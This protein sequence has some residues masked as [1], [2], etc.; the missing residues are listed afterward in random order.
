MNGMTLKPICMAA[1]LTLGLPVLSCNRQPSPRE[2]AERLASTLDR[3]ENLQGNALWQTF[4]HR[5]EEAIKIARGGAIPSEP[6]LVAAVLVR[7]EKTPRRG[8]MGLVW[9]KRED[10][11]DY[12]TVKCVVLEAEGQTGKQAVEVPLEGGLSLLPRGY[13]WEQL[14]DVEVVAGNRIAYRIEK[15]TDP[16]TEAETMTILTI[17]EERL[18]EELRVFLRD[19]AGRTSDSLVVAKLR[20]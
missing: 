8:F 16:R 10:K 9:L 4:P 2:H 1:A 17:G 14:I 12:S 6:F 20:G 15:E 7:N 11:P 3:L 13:C 18:K 5:L 19:E